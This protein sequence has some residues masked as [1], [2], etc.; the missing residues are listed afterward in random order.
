MFIFSFPANKWSAS[1][2]FVGFSVSVS[3]LENE[4][5][6]EGPAAGTG[7]GRFSLLQDLI[8]RAKLADFKSLVWNFY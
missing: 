6:A 7:S 1:D 2:F 5:Q 3:S 4:K 8:T